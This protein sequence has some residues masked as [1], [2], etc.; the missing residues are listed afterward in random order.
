MKNTLFV[1][2]L[3]SAASISA[4]GDHCRTTP[5]GPGERID[6]ARLDQ[7]T[8]TRAADALQIT[9]AFVEPLVHCIQTAL[10]LSQAEETAREKLLD[11]EFSKMKPAKRREVLSHAASAH[12]ASNYQDHVVH[13]TR[14][15]TALVEEQTKESAKTY[16]AVRKSH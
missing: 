12:Q 8:K 2:T 5:M 9:P 3:L 10:R 7:S 14:C 11:K 4:C 16:T 15:A 13:I 1:I 6:T